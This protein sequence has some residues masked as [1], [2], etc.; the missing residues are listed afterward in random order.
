ME[1]WHPISWQSSVFLN[2]TTLALAAKSQIRL[3]QFRVEA[4]VSHGDV[5]QPLLGYELL[6][7]TIGRVLPTDMGITINLNHSASPQKHQHFLDV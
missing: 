7:K 3:A 4:S 2:I 5:N 6:N 1:I